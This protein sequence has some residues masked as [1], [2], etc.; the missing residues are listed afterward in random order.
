MNAVFYSVIASATM[1]WMARMVQPNLKATT[2]G[3]L[4]GI[5]QIGVGTFSWLLG[6]FVKSYG[7]NYFPHFAGCASAIATIFSAIVWYREGSD[8]YNS[9]S[10]GDVEEAV[11]LKENEEK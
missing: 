11:E 5:Q 9:Y 3:V 1:P 8:P 6:K 10:H 2:M 7:W 4:M